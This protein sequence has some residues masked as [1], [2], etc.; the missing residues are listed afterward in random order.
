MKSQRRHSVLVLGL[1]ILL[2]RGTVLSAVQANTMALN[3]ALSDGVDGDGPGVCP[4][5]KSD[6]SGK[7]MSHCPSFCNIANAGI[8]SITPAVIETIPLSYTAKLM[9]SPN[10][11]VGDVDPSPPNFQS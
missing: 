6:D 5:C 7:A 9:W 3:L 1:A 8:L 10:A 2:G 4:A 11:F